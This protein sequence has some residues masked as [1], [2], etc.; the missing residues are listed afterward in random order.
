MFF[1]FGSGELILFL[2]TSWLLRVASNCFLFDGLTDLSF[3][4]V[5]GHVI[6]G[7]MVGILAAAM[8]LFEG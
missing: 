4:I 6:R 5:G 2:T 1:W 8:P 3:A 7:G